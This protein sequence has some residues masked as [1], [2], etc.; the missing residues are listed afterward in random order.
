MRVFALVLCVYPLISAATCNGD[1]SGECVSVQDA[2]S[3]L[4]VKGVVARGTERLDEA[5]AS[6][7]AFRAEK[8]GWPMTCTS[9][10]RGCATCPECLPMSEQQL[11]L[12]PEIQAPLEQQQCSAPM[13]NTNYCSTHAFRG[14]GPQSERIIGV[15]VSDGGKVP[16]LQVYAEA[17]EIDGPKRVGSTMECHESYFEPATSETADG[18]PLD[19]FRTPPWVMCRRPAEGTFDCGSCRCIF[20]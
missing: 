18:S 19:Q 9:P 15:L 16:D 5:C 3:L 2:T 14:T 10:L 11:P 20:H 17:P 7:C 4:Q 8:K 6:W 1:D 13:C 12:E